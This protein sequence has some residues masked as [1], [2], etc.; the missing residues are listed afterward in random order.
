MTIHVRRKYVTEP[1]G[2]VREETDAEFRERV[3]REGNDPAAER[4]QKDMDDIVAA[5]EKSLP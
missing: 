5:I 1:D 2:S 3:V 4:M